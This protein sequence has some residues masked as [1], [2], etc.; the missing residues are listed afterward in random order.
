LF[1][2]LYVVC[3]GCSVSTPLLINVET[4]LAVVGLFSMALIGKVG[5]F[6]AAVALSLPTG[7]VHLWVLELN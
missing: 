1:G 4:L 7:F 5:Q 3:R 2:L 6:S